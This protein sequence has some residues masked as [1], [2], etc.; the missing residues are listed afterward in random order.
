MIGNVWEWARDTYD[1]GFYG[2]GGTTDPVNTDKGTMGVVRGG[3]WGED[4]WENWRASNRF[5]FWR[6]N[7]IEGIGFRC[8]MPE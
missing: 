5:K 1:P 3:G 6:G 2:S 4:G 8:A 7:A